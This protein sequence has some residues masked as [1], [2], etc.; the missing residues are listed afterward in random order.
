MERE[1]L[2]QVTQTVPA[3]VVPATL[4]SS[5]MTST[6]DSSGTAGEQDKLRKWLGF[7]VFDIVYLNDN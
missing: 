6:N 2:T 3:T 4:T 5:S 7:I 1:S